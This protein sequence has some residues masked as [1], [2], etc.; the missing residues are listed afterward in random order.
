MSRFWLTVAGIAFGAATALA[1]GDREIGK[2]AF[3]SACVGCHG[4][5]PVPRAMSLAQMAELPPEKI[6]HAQ[7]QGMMTLQ[8]SALTEVE[9]RA[10]AIYVS[11][12]PWGSVPEEHIEESLQRCESSPPLAANALDKAHWSGWGLDLDNSHFQPAEHAGLSGA[13]L[14]ELELKWAFGFA[15]AT[16]VSTQPAVAGGRIFLGSE[17]GGIY[18]LDA[19]TGCAHW[20][21]DTPAAYAAPCCSTPARAAPTRSMPAIARAG[22]TLWMPTAASCYGKTAG[23]T[24]LGL[25]DRFGR[26][27]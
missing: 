20:K 27:V 13:G 24:R 23:P 16:T 1:D 8:A 7:T 19:R 6:V 10:L 3:E 15:G 5:K 22:S 26:F 25:G 18:S 14:A 12:I 17:Q 9:K 21:F 4:E 2:R 11:E